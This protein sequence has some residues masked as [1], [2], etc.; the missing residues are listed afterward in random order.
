[1]KLTFDRFTTTYSTLAVFK[2]IQYGAPIMLADEMSKTYLVRFG[3]YAREV[4]KIE[5]EIA[6]DRYYI[7]K[8]EEVMGSGDNLSTATRVFKKL[9]EE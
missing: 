9:V 4:I 3:Q 7:I 5:E 6:V 8:N 2:E 1:M